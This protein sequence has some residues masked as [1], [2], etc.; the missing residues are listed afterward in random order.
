MKIS[1][2]F[3]VLI[4]VILGIVSCSKQSSSAAPPRSV[5]ETE[6][7]KQSVPLIQQS[8]MSLPSKTSLE[9]QKPNVQRGLQSKKSAPKDEKAERDNSDDGEIK[10]L[11]R[12]KSLA[13]TLADMQLNEQNL[14]EAML[15]ACSKKISRSCP[16]FLEAKAR[17]PNQPAIPYFDDAQESK[18]PEDLSIEA[19]TLAAHLRLLNEGLEDDRR[20]II[21][22]RLSD[23]YSDRKVAR[24]SERGV[25]DMGMGL[26]YIIEEAPLP[27][28]S[29][30]AK[31]TAPV[32]LTWQSLIG[33][34]HP[35]FSGSPLVYHY[36]TKY[37]DNLEGENKT[38][39]AAWM[40]N[41][42]TAPSEY[43][44]W[45]I[46]FA[47]NIPFDQLTAYLAD[48]FPSNYAIILGKST[49]VQY[50]QQP[51]NVI[52]DIEGGGAIAWLIYKRKPLA[53]GV[54]LSPDALNALKLQKYKTTADMASSLT[55]KVTKSSKTT[56]SPNREEEEDDDEDAGSKW[57][58]VMLIVAFLLF[59]VAAVLLF[60]LA[61]QRS[62][63][64]GNTYSK[65]SKKK[66]SII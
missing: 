11:K 23:A 19:L 5:V 35:I 43:S 3:P 59:A 45:A 20:K 56:K 64:P 32:K 54:N 2:F 44:M 21:I 30:D 24:P 25:W 51:E 9:E 53:P 46:V 34:E 10:E 49:T 12:S 16:Q 26:K 1:P 13:N 18:T 15:F 61:K 62:E 60:L 66:I 58:D 48:R 38:D 14:N 28:P 27:L 37:V 17:F 57:F 39:I 6:E 4:H 7:S 52:I 40:Q 29:T 33:M 8:S 36:I 47:K 42:H 63:S 50:E 41:N 65:V 55:K 22:D 31:S